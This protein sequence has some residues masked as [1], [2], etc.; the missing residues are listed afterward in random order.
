MSE[1]RKWLASGGRPLIIV[2]RGEWSH[3][4]ENSLTAIRAARGYD[5]V[6]I[7]VQLSSDGIP[8]VMHDDTTLR[9]A[10]TDLRV[11]DSTAAE[12]STL[13]LLDS[14]DRIPLLSE[15]LI[16]GGPNLLF[17]LDVKDE[18][19]LEA[20]AHFM[21]SHRE[22][23]RCLLKMDVHGA[24]DVDRL[25][26]VEGRTGICVIAKHVIDGS[27][28]VDL[29]KVLAARNVAAAEVWYPSLDMLAECARVGP[30]LTT[31]TLNAVHCCGLS[32]AAAMSDPVS[33]WGALVDVGVSG[34]MT[35]TPAH[36]EQ[37]L[38]GHCQ[39]KLA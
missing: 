29:L 39:R 23:G 11:A 15:A 10:G 4:P 16:A 36:L 9:T 17:D 19:E 14:E 26:D 6:E 38:I 2:H 25:L 3:A 8:I 1:V 12:L 33:V 32:D 35:D 21:S 5:M 22:S 27:A 13:T 7:D 34:I 30:P 24:D 31:Y 28:S 37:Y 20:V 18:N